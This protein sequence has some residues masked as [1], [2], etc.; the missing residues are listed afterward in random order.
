MYGAPS[1]EW[2]ERCMI[3]G[4]IIEQMEVVPEKLDQFMLWVEE[5]ATIPNRIYFPSKFCLLASG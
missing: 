1:T 2:Y 3:E 5:A 4:S